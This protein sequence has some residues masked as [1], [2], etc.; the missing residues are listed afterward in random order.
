MNQLSGTLLSLLLMASSAPR[1]AQ[2]LQ[3]FPPEESTQTYVQYVAAALSFKLGEQADPRSVQLFVD[4][5]DVTSQSRI[6][7]TRDWPISHLEIGYTPNFSESGTHHAEVRFRT[8]DG[9][10]KSYRWSFSVKSP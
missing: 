3:V 5:V 10:T 8:L 6:G 2:L 9:K 4:G 7:N 1:P